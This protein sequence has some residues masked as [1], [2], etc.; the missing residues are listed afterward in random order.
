MSKTRCDI[1]AVARQSERKEQV[2]ARGLRLWRQKKKRSWQQRQAGPRKGSAS[3]LRRRLPSQ[4]SPSV[5]RAL[6]QSTFETLGRRHVVPGADGAR[7]SA[8]HVCGVVRLWPTVQWRQEWQRRNS[9][10]R[11]KALR[12]VDLRTAPK[13]SDARTLEIPRTPPRSVSSSLRSPAL[14]SPR[15]AHGGPRGAV[16][17]GGRGAQ[18]LPRAPRGP[19]PTTGVEMAVQQ[20]LPGRPTRLAARAPGLKRA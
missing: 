12:T 15:P 5:G 16:A 20:H 18:A 7:A 10:R 11:P 13:R 14:P 4:K 8:R 9:R 19:A 17:R 6:R 1:F 2:D 3:C